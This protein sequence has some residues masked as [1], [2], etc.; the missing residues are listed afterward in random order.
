[1]NKRSFSLMGLVMAVIFLAAATAS[2]AAPSRAVTQL[3]ATLKGTD[4]TKGGEPNGTGTATLSIDSTANSISYTIKVTGATLPMKA[5]HIHEGAAGVAGPVV[6][7]L[8]APDASGTATG[9]VTST[10][11][12]IQKILANPA[13]YYVNVHNAPYPDGAMRGQLMMAS[14]GGLPNTGASSHSGLLVVLALAVLLVGMGLIYVALRRDD[15]P[16]V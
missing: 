10:A 13:G 4:E 11:D 6:Q 12:L 14:A 1:M 8:G 5:G 2:F 15:A 7:P 16:A 3:T 9:T